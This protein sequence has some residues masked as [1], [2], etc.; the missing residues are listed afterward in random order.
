MTKPSVRHAALVGAFIV[1]L[2]ALCIVWP[3][4]Y[5]YAADV[6]AFHLLSLK[7]T[8]PGF[9][10]MEAGSILWGGVLSFV[11]GFVGSLIFHA[12]H[13]ACCRK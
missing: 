7:L 5:P 11:Y 13:G 6:Q 10:G 9:Q 1:L 12:L 8:F 2:Y 4:V 3:L